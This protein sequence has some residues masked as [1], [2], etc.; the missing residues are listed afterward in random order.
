MT[1]EDGDKPLWFIVFQDDEVTVNGGH[2]AFLPALRMIRLSAAM[3]NK[4]FAIGLFKGDIT[5]RKI[6]QT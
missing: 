4:T 6:I 1:L 5:D 3:R 2:I